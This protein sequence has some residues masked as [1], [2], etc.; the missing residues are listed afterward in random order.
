MI[1]IESLNHIILIHIYIY[2]SLKNIFYL[3]VISVL[4]Y[5]NTGRYLI[6]KI[7]LQ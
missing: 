7:I 4:N 5:S 2:I 1:I 3:F 6:N